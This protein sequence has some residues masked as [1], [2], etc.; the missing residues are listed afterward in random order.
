MNTR[1]FLPVLV[2]FLSLVVFT[3]A[4][5]PE[6]P[7][8]A[9]LKPVFENMVG[10]IVTSKEAQPYFGSIALEPIKATNATN[11]HGDFGWILRWT[12]SQGTT[13]TPVNKPESQ[14]SAY[15]KVTEDHGI[16]FDIFIAEDKAGGLISCDQTYLLSKKPPIS[17]GYKLQTKNDDPALRKQIEHVIPLYLPLFQEKIIQFRK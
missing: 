15:P 17:L 16:I 12:V 1:N 3:S 7:L 2:L 11:I 5:E 14:I 9:A 6:N 10:E 8:R 13:M 4:E